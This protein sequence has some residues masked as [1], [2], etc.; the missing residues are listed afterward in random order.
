[1]LRLRN[2]G[3]QAGQVAAVGVFAAA[4][5]AITI[6]TCGHAGVWHSDASLYPH[7]IRSN[8]EDVLARN[9]HAAMFARHNRH[10]EAV[11]VYDNLLEIFPQH[12][13]AP[14]YRAVSLLQIDGS[15]HTDSNTNIQTALS[16]FDRM[17]S[18]E[19]S[20]DDVRY[21]RAR[22]LAHLKRFAEAE[23][24]YETLIEAHPVRPDGAVPLDRHYDQAQ[25]E[26]LGLVW[27]RYGSLRQEQ[28]RHL[29]AEHCFRQVLRT[30]AAVMVETRAEAMINLATVLMSS[31]DNRKDNQ[32][33]LA[34]VARL[35]ENARRMAPTNPYVLINRANGKA[36]WCSSRC[37]E[38]TQP[39]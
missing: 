1:M 35:R 2:C 32:A 4:I 34:E 16:E 20:R 27:M 28:Q 18:V 3:G 26:L 13:K 21:H 22:A 38:V 5:V 23:A 31:V 36:I 39:Y 6:Q 8:P 33:A 14:L 17:L 24:E 29:E 12:P 30:T 19:Q 37:M 15:T 11:R 25:D 9:N 7:L 10:A